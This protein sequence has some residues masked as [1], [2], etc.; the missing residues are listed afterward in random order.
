[1]PSTETTKTRMIRAAFD[2][3]HKQGV[4]AT[5]VDEILEA[6]GTGKS[7]FYYY[8]KNKEELIHEV[9]IFFYDKMKSGVGVKYKIESWEDLRKWFQSF[10][11]FQKQVHSER[12]CPIGTIGS[13]LSNG[14]Q[15]LR[16]DVRLI[17]ELMSRPLID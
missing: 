4:H 10:I 12:M 16:Q 1:M 13:E 14:Q 5:S 2:L 15:L 8:F 11:G 17:F 6:S 3:F 7:Q 9:L